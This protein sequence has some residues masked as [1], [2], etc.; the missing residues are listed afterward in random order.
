MAQKSDEVRTMKSLRLFTDIANSLCFNH[1]DIAFPS[2]KENTFICTTIGLGT[3][4]I[5]E[6]HGCHKTSRPRNIGF[7][8]AALR[9]P[10][11]NEKRERR[12]SLDVSPLYSLVKNRPIAA[13]NCCEAQAYAALN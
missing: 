12:R 5:H 8:N 11:T 1:L 9:K 3:A 6:R 2:I 13:A 7:A 10:P 4:M